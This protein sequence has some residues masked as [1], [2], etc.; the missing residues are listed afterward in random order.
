MSG[1]ANKDSKGTTASRRASARKSRR[2]AS[3]RSKTRV[4]RSYQH[5]ADE[6]NWVARSRRHSSAFPWEK[7]PGAVLLVGCAVLLISFLTHPAFRVSAISVWGQKLAGLDEITSA[8]GIEGQTIFGVNPGQAEARILT[9]CPSIEFVEVSSRLPNDVAIEVRERNIATVWE[10]SGE[11]FLVDETG[12]ILI[13]REIVGQSV[14]IQDQD[15]FQ[16]QPGDRVSLNILSLVW[17]LNRSMPEVNQFLYSEVHGVSIV[18]PQGWPVYF[19]TDGDP[20]FK[21]GLLKAL[22]ADFRTRGIHPQYVDLRLDQRPAY[23]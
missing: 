10:T 6:S 11:R 3:R 7:S 20:A 8:L 22:M 21:V 14:L 12:L 18:T 23:R 5:L 19:G 1:R 4:G 16:R 2:K 9:R 17:E 15:G 13:W